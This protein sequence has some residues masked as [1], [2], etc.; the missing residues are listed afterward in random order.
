M[1]GGESFEEL[2]MWEFK[3]VA[4]GSEPL[5]A[6]LCSLIFPLLAEVTSIDKSFISISQVNESML[7]TTFW[8]R[9]TLNSMRT[10]T[11]EKFVI[12]VIM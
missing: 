7:P 2:R 4:L 11:K 5:R 1:G 10:R 8:P 3:G 6:V 9:L 12:S